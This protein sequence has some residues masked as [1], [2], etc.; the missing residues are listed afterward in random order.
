MMSST[1][2]PKIKKHSYFLCGL[3]ITIVLSIA[4]AKFAY[5][6]L[7]HYFA[8]VAGTVLIIDAIK[9]YNANEYNFNKRILLELIMGAYIVSE[10]IY[11]YTV[12]LKGIIDF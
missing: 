12:F 5:L 2:L 6:G 11:L 7:L 4:A 8:F 1:L 3:F 9:D 10:H